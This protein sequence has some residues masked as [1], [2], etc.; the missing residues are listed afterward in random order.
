MRNY[1]TTLAGL[2]TGLPFL[3]D[4]LMQ[5]YTAGYFTDKSGWQ[6]F[7]SIAWIIVTRLV[8]DHDATGGQRI[9][10]GSTPPPEKDEK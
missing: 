8:K 1:K 7:G 6:L 2:L 5:A 3:I 10:G 9:I 4:A